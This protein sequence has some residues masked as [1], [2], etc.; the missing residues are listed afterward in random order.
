MS[1][2]A[3]VRQLLKY[4]W[5]SF[6]SRFGNLTP[7]QIAAIPKILEG[8]NT[9]VASPTASGKTEAVVA[10]VAEKHIREQW[11]GLAVV[12]IIPTRSLANDTLQ[13]IEGPLSE[14]DIK[15]SLKHGDKP[16]LPAKLPNWLITTPESLDSLLCRH[17]E[18]FNS[19]R[20]II[21]DEIHFL[22]NTYRGDQLRC[23][24]TRLRKLVAVSH[25]QFSVHLL[26][27][28]LADPSQIATRYVRDFEVVSVPGQRAIKSYI[29]PSLE[30]ICNFAKSQ[31]MKKILCFCNLRKSVESVAKEMSRLW[32]HYTVVTHYGSLSRQKREEAEAVMK[33]D[34][35][36]ICVATSTL[37]I[38]IDIGNV[39]LIILAEVPWSINSLLQRIGRGNRRDDTVHVAALAKSEEER[40]QLE[41]MFEAAVTG[42]LPIEP[43]AADL[44][45]AIQQ[46][47]SCL[48]QHP[49][50]VT[51][52]E[53]GELLEI[54]CHEKDLKIIL[55]HLRQAE[56]ME[57]AAGRWYRS[58]KLSNMADKGYIHSNIPDEQTCHVI[59]IGSGKEIGTIGRGFDKTFVLAQKSWVVVAADNKKV[60]VRRYQGEAGLPVFQ[61]HPDC[62]AFHSYLP[63][64]LRQGKK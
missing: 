29:L 18:V 57:Y 11:E 15:I 54:F 51:E 21:L 10:P 43:Y 45:V 8:M 59:D 16:H 64:E 61:Y 38:G 48:Y 60:Q 19:L 23:L 7:I 1:D 6:F 28:T 32:N 12:Y 55:G 31:N 33:E 20:T 35:N 3:D 26:S 46:I 44:S 63:S 36:A 56:W 30:E 5:P 17:S 24:L 4:S 41:S 49:E 9:V 27:A 42:T 25:S 40:K 62:G 13:R 47:F 39:D 2:I 37:E 53:L 58:E 22:D 52:P 14:M 34:T 50:G